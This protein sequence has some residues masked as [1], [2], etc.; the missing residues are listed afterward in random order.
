MRLEKVAS[1]VGP[2]TPYGTRFITWFMKIDGTAPPVELDNALFLSKTMLEM[3]KTTK[4][5]L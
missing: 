5:S 2:V 4:F 3:K 1:T